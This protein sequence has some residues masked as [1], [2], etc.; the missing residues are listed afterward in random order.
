MYVAFYTQVS[1]VGISVVNDMMSVRSGKIR[2]RTDGGVGSHRAHGRTRPRR[3][4]SWENRKVEV[5]VEVEVCFEP[6][7][8]P[9]H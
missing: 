9:S 4:S 6:Q 2:N 5:E 3:R 8:W 1:I 7:P